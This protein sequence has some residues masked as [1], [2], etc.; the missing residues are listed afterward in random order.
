M[1]LKPLH[2]EN[3]DGRRKPE[4]LRSSQAWEPEGVDYILTQD[5][6]T[7]CGYLNVN[8]NQ[9]K[10]NEITKSFPQSTNHIVSTQRP[11]R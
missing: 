11:Q 4:Y 8:V 3:Q 7:A 10:W 1:E 6:L 5:P 9:L 2:M